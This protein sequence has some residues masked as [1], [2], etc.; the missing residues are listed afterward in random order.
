MEEEESTPIEDEVKPQAKAVTEEEEE[1][2]Q[3]ALVVV[4]EKSDNK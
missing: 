1:E 4:D 3:N 2:P